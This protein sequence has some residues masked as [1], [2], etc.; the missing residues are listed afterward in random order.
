MP[1]TKTKKGLTMTEQKRERAFMIADRL[2]WIFIENSHPK[3][4]D[5]FIEPDP[6]N[7][8]GTRNTER[9]K[10]LFDVLK[11]NIIDEIES[12]KVHDFQNLVEKYDLEAHIIDGMV[13]DL[14]HAIFEER[15]K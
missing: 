1:I 12:M 2:Y 5:D 14:V 15:T 3:S 13:L 7:L 8:Q 4:I 9:G 11:E 6:D 10:E